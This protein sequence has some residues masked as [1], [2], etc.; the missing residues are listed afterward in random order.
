MLHDEEFLGNI[1][2]STKVYNRRPLSVF[3]DVNKAYDDSV[4]NTVD[5]VSSIFGEE[6]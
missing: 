5:A 2:A 3:V 6:I 1:S 4:S